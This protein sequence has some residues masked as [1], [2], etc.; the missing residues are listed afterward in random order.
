M[1]QLQK[2]EDFGFVKLDDQELLYINGGGFGFW[3]GL[4]A[5]TVVQ[6]VVHSVTGRSLVE[7]AQAAARRVEQAF[8][9]VAK[10]LDY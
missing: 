9:D 1:D 2:V 7:H 5:S 8:I 3:G 10:A 6:A 4:M